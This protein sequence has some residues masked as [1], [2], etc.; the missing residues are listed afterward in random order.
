MTLATH[1]LWLREDLATTLELEVTFLPPP[2]SSL[3]ALSPLGCQESPS[4][5]PRLQ[6]PRGQSHIRPFLPDLD[7][8][9]SALSEDPRQL[10]TALMS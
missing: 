9:P 1:L 2:W 3:T 6:A 10:L 4:L 7:T 8:K 5:P